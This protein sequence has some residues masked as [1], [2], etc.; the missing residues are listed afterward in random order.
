MTSVPAPA[1]TVSSYDALSDAL[2][3]YLRHAGLLVGASIALQV[4]QVALTFLYLAQAGPDAVAATAPVDGLASQL[5]IA[6][7]AIVLLV[8]RQTGRGPS[9]RALLATSGS[10]L[11][12][13]LAVAVVTTAAISLAAPFVL[14]SVILACVLA[15]AAPVVVTRDASPVEAVRLSWEL[16]KRHLGSVFA[17]VVVQALVVLGIPYLTEA[18]VPGGLKDWLLVYSAF[19][20]LVLPW[21]SMAVA[22]LAEQLE[23][24]Q[25]DGAP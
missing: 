3:M 12:P 2:R 25:S 17:V 20:A 21:T 24:V 8:H 1:P 11:L 10:R 23:A 15:V 18:L 14:V 7:C 9:P 5:T 16:T 22:M 13:L 4:L 6:V 19:M